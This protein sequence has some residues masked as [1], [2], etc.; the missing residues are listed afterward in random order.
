MMEQ[1]LL[2]LEEEEQMER[3]DVWER[4]RS[5]DK[6]KERRQTTTVSK[7]AKHRIEGGEGS[8]VSKRKRLE[9][10]IIGEEWGNKEPEGQ[11]REPAK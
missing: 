3:I 2:E 9:H 7:G 5:Q 6:A 1:E 10:P 8:K 4:L 11:E